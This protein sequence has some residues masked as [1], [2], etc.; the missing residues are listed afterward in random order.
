MI[1]IIDENAERID[2]A[3]ELLYSFLDGFQ[4]ENTQVQLQLLT[5]IDMLFLKK[6]TETQDLVQT[7]QVPTQDK[8][9]PDSGD[10]GHIYWRLLS[11]DSAAAK[12]VVLVEKPLSSVD[13]LRL[14]TLSSSA[15]WLRAKPATQG[16]KRRR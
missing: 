11:T 3:N 2:N 15:K 4:H 16:Y 7:T 1:W 5:V 12:D 10:R 6:P 9:N 13:R 14:P 8:D